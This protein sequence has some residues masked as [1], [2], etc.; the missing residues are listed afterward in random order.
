MKTVKWLLIIVL[1]YSG[2]LFAQSTKNVE[3]KQ[4]I[5]SGTG[6]YLR[7]NYTAA[8]TDFEI[9]L[10]MQPDNRQTRELLSKVIIEGGTSC[11]SKQQYKQGLAILEKGRRLLPENTQI[12]ELYELIKKQLSG[13]EQKKVPNSQ[14]PVKKMVLSSSVPTPK[15]VSKQK[16]TALTQDEPV[17]PDIL[18]KSDKDKK[19]HSPQISQSTKQTVYSA[20]ESN[21][22]NIV[23]KPD[24]NPATNGI[25]LILIII[26]LIGIIMS[27]FFYYI[28][29]MK[30]EWL[31]YNDALKKDVE[32]IRTG[33]A[34]VRD[35]MQQHFASET[36]QK[37]WQGWANAKIIQLIATLEDF[38]Y[39]KPMNVPLPSQ[40][41]QPEQVIVNQREKFL[42][43][44]KGLSPDAFVDDLQNLKDT[45]AQLV[46]SA[47]TLYEYDSKSAL[48]TL[49]ELSSD[50]RP[51]VQANAIWVLAEIGT[52]ETIE[53][54]L[55][56]KDTKEDK[57]KRE[58]IQV[59]NNLS[60]R[61][62]LPESLRLR[63]KNIIAEEKSNQD[64]VF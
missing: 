39:K 59:L 57:V 8:L 17:S 1:F 30:A 16:Q 27:F 49:D 60:K 37:K 22:K 12:I 36:E 64:W 5:E 4:Y 11:Y 20:P 26:L 47:T 55:K 3:L 14:E 52:P 9:A 42:G 33:L 61:Y 21:S 40:I 19:D 25:F 29:Q 62:D 54:L 38:G 31:R 51:I 56:F 63:I 7:G 24:L 13:P 44:V 41:K 45:R 43:Q 35:K 23:F 46:K 32:T 48:K 2:Y 6:K 18:S 28:Q 53:M 15:T 58:F 34:E 10:E 50:P